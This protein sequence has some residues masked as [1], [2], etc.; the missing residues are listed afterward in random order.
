MTILTIHNNGREV[1]IKVNNDGVVTELNT[2]EEINQA[3]A[4][5]AEA[6]EKAKQEKKE[7]EW[8]AYEGYNS[9][10]T[11]VKWGERL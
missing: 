2:Q 5:I 10:P 7:L 3:Y 4:E 6:N 8:W 9:D 1:T 11:K